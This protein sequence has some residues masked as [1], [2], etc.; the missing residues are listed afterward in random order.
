MSILKYNLKKGP[1]AFLYEGLYQAIRQDILTGQLRPGRRLPSKREMAADNGI[2]LT[3]VMN[4]YQ[5][6]LMEGL[7]VS[8][9]KKG[10]FVADINVLPS[11]KRH[12]D[13]F[14]GRYYHEYKWFADFRAN[15]T[16]FNNFPFS[17]WKKTVREVLSEYEIEL[18][19]KGNPF[20]IEDLRIQ[21]ADYL[22]RTRA[23]K[24]IP[25]CIIIGA[26]I[27]YL[28]ARLITLFPSHTIYAV[29]TP[30][31][32]KIPGIYQAYRLRWK[33]IGMDDSGISM[34]DLR[35]SDANIVHVSP[36]HHYPLGIIMPAER[37]HA[38]LSWAD[39]DEQR[40]IIE[41]DYDC[42]FIYN[43]RPIPA[44]K[45]Q[46]HNGKV[47][48]MNTFSKTLSPAVRISYMVLP[49]KL[50]EK[51][52]NGTHFFINSASSLEQYA[53]SRFMESGH[54]ERHLSKIRRLYRQAG[55][56]LI[57]AVKDNPAIPVSV[58]TGGESGT[59]ILLKL[60]TNLTDREI[61]TKAA[62]K[63]INLYCLSEFCTVPDK[64]YDRTIVLNF[65]DMNEETQK[66]AIHRLASIFT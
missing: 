54:F 21:I 15:N 24:V 28:Y 27:E 41:D 8:E 47:I 5:Q 40:Y 16:L 10:Y 65:S 62:E 36:E 4:A 18:V 33:S 37:R 3:T 6:L 58:L 52:I 13:K 50:L 38:L 22:E 39:E 30:G 51:Y 53:V 31:Y 55:E 46:D 60:D 63:G 43:R 12:T 25:E 1:D 19:R 45:S 57:K 35:I 26:G 61:K 56:R 44:L 66:E 23:I 64:R 9:E 11:P 2:S 29:E 59:H 42:E 7:I 34:A 49:E 20:G 48:Y 17:T 14:I 32:R